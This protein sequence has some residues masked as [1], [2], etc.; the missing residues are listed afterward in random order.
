MDVM[1]IR[2]KPWLAYLALLALLVLF[3][4]PVYWIIQISLQSNAELFRFPP[5]MLTAHP[6]FGSYKSVLSSS[7][8]LTF[9]WNTVIVAIGATVLCMSVSVLAGYGISRFPFGGSRLLVLLVLSTQMFPSVTL[10][11]GLY[12][13]YS[14]LHLLNTPIALILATTT[15][16]LPFCMLMMRTFFDS[17]ARELDEAAE[18]DG[19][20]R[21]RTLI[22]VVLPLAKPGLVAVAIYTFLIAWD[23]FLFGLA[24]VSD[25]DKRTLSPGLSLTYLGEFG[26]NWSGAAAAAVT[27]TAPLLAAFLLLQRYMIDGLT[28]GG[29]KE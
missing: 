18:M 17:I 4:F 29:V 14:K 21:I 13:L 26:Y 22:Q 19:A 12:T 15:T 8:F 10:L 20:S 5:R 7:L 25:L 3:L 6:F 11:I 28:A 2:S 1:T 23:D 27:A 24:L 16:A 9:Y